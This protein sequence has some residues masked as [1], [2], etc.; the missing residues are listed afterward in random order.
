MVNLRE[1]RIRSGYIA[2]KKCT[3]CRLEFAEDMLIYYP[4]QRVALC[5]NCD[6]KRGKQE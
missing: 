6:T 3:D 4:R 5:R 2:I 1:G